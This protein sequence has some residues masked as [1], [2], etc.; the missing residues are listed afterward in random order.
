[1]DIDAVFSIMP[2]FWVQHS[3]LT[4]VF[5]EIYWQNCKCF[6]MINL[7]NLLFGLITSISSSPWVPLAVSMLV[8]SAEIPVSGLNIIWYLHALLTTVVSN[9]KW[10]LSFFHHTLRLWK[11]IKGTAF[12]YKTKPNTNTT[13]TTWDVYIST[14]M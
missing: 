14:K 9:L 5:E 3:T 2:L 11:K 13:T 10:L 4:H 8:A 1:M 12:P 6:W 7:I